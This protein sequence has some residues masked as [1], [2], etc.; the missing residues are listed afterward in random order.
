MFSF[1]CLT[2]NYHSENSSKIC[3]SRSKNLHRKYR[4]IDI[5]LAERKKLE[6]I[7]TNER[8]TI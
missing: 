1:Y 4:K 2:E 3:G 8:R 5:F 6:K 7:L